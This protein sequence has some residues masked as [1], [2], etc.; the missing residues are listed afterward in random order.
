M[1]HFA[2]MFPKAAFK[3]SDPDAGARSSIDAWVRQSGLT[4]VSSALELDVTAPPDLSPV[5]VVI[6]INMIHIAPPDATRGLVQLA[7]NIIRSG[8]A[9]FLYGPFKRDGAH[10]AH[11][12]AAFDQSLRARDPRWGIRNLEDVVSLGMTAGFS[13]HDVIEMPANNLSVILRRA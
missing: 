5:D 8:G 4:N 7:G 13:A 1:V 2:E 6:C 12:N 10:T 11:S 9:L 3:P